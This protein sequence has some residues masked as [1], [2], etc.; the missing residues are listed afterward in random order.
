MREQRAK[1]SR[2]NDTTKAINY[3]L[4][5]WDASVQ[6]H[7]FWLLLPGRHHPLVRLLDACDI[8]SFPLTQF[9]DPV[10]PT[11]ASLAIAS[12]RRPRRLSTISLPS[13]NGPSR[14]LGR[15]R[16]I[17][18]AQRLVSLT[19]SGHIQLRRYEKTVEIDA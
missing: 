6:G 11:R 9:L 12:K 15:M 8:A 2:N 16:T 17:K 5:R 18:C 7:F 1:L 3:C 10:V 19:G 13:K 14:G 4:S